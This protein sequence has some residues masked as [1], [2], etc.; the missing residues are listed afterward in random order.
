MT[1]ARLLRIPQQKQSRRAAE[2]G[3]RSFADARLDIIAVVNRESFHE[4]GDKPLASV[5][6]R[7]DVD[8]WKTLGFEPGQELHNTGVQSI[9][10]P[11]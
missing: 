4:R 5:T 7:I 2:E 3:S 9:D 10:K 11:K 8:A 6:D 1:N